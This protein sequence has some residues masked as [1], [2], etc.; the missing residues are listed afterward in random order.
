V[1]PLRL[2]RWILWKAVFWSTYGARSVF[3]VPFRLL[4]EL[5][6]A[7]LE[8][9]VAEERG[10]RVALEVER[11]RLAAELEARVGRRTP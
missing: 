5:A 4:S 3:D 2:C 6:L 11:D 8:R 10:E 9:I 7:R 1:R